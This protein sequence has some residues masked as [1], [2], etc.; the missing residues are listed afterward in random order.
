[1]LIFN[2]ES[3]IIKTSIGKDIYLKLNGLKN[4]IKDFGNF[5]DRCLKEIV[6]WEDYILYAITLNESKTLSKQVK[7]ELNKL[8]HIVY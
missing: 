8:I 5:D 4:Y 7:E 6:L 3:T 2:K 1:M